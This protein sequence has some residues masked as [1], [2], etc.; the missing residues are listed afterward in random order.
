MSGRHRPGAA[1]RA[2]LA[3]HAWREPRRRAW[4]VRQGDVTIATRRRRTEAAR[5]LAW[6]HARRLA[7]DA[8]RGLVMASRGAEG[9][10]GA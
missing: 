8:R 7:V 6:P 10:G 1:G 4:T 2:R 3:W 9:H 5:M